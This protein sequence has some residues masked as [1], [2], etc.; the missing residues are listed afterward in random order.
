M[1]HKITGTRE[2]DIPGHVTHVAQRFQEGIMAFAAGS[3]IVGEVLICLDFW[4]ISMFLLVLWYH[5]HDFGLLFE[6]INSIAYVC[7]C[8]QT[9]GVGLLIATEFTDNKSPYELFPFEWGK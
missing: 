1:F 5:R 4:N 9:R 6:H 8:T 3:P 2:R 7:S